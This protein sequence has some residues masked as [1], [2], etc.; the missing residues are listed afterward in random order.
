M[1]FCATY[2]IPGVIYIRPWEGCPGAYFQVYTLTAL[3][4]WLP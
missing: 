1:Y 2:Q 3:M 4:Y